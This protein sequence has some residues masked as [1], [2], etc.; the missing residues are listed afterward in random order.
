VVEIL[1]GEGFG[2]ETLDGVAEV[3][4][5]RTQIFMA[6]GKGERQSI[7]SLSV[8]GELVLLSGSGE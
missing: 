4:A 5:K 1:A 2:D 7:Q 3:V 6:L 8:V